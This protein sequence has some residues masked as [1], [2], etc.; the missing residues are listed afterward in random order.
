M[1]T[2]LKLLALV[3]LPTISS[4]LVGKTCIVP[5]PRIENTT[6]ETIELAKK[7][8]ALNIM[9]SEELTGA[10]A[11]GIKLLEKRIGILG[12][13]P[14]QSN[15]VPSYSSV[16]LDLCTVE[17]M[18]KLL[19]A[20]I[21]EEELEPQRLKQ[22]YYIKSSQ[23]NATG[24]V[25]M[26]KACDNLGLYYGII[27]LCQL[28]DTDEDGNLVASVGE[29]ID[30]PE[31]AHRLAKTSASFNA[32]PKVSRFAQWMSL[33][34]FS[35][36]GLQYHGSNSKNPEDPFGPNII[37]QCS[38]YR[39][40]GTLE[41]IVY[42]C[43]FRGKDRNR[44]D[45]T[46]EEDRV[47][48]TKYLLWIMSQGAYGI[49]IDYNDWPFSKVPIA[50]VI[51]LACGILSEKYPDAYILYC[52]PNVGNQSYRGM[53]SPALAHTL[54][55]VPTN[56]WPLWTGITG[57]MVKPLEV[58]QVAQWTKITSRRPFLWVNRVSVDVQYSFS[59]ELEGELKGFVFCG[60]RLPENLNQLFQG[61]HFN[62]G[63]GSGYNEL[64][65]TFTAEAIAYVA[66]AADYVWNPHGW[67]AEESLR[68]AKHFVEV[69]TPLVQGQRFVDGDS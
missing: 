30:F 12:Y 8:Q 9:I 32:P 52:P 13:K 1:S 55:Q 43:P 33:Y 11:E 14:I 63:M 46:F 16:G 57:K 10:L 17:Q 7:G 69:M 47:S 28:I 64:P 53:A 60:E 21:V 59:R 44:Y 34:K 49:E 26:I 65:D 42:F 68:R 58:A 66:T 45:F 6:E 67:Y 23:T 50:D 36:L 15:P 38:Y 31:I 24:P 25:V 5:R 56:V 51:N 4:V 29:I 20:N 40:A 3:M 2:R 27:S 62:T 39:K 22:A 18:S 54:S 35:Q 41:T 61:V 19:R 48:Y 37:Q